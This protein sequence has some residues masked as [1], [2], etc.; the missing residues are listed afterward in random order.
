MSDGL[1]PGGMRYLAV[2]HVTADVLDDRGIQPG[3]TALYSALQAARLGLSATI[4]TRGEPARVRALLAPFED[5]I[6]LIVQP[7]PE[8]TT[9][10]TE[11]SGA[12]RRQRVLSW[13]GPI[14]TGALPAAEILHLAPV[15]AELP[16]PAPGRWRFVGL[17]PQGYARR[18][19][20][21]GATLAS[22]AADPSF[23]LSAGRCDAVVISVLERDS[24]AELLAAA[25]AAGAVAAVTAGPSPMEIL[26]PGGGS[27][28]V[29]V[30]SLAEPVDDLGAGDVYAAAFFAA[31]AR[32]DE[33]AAAARMARAAAALRMIGR[34]PGAVANAEAIGE[35][36]AREG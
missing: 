9:F 10:A 24:C 19:D 4:V 13:A 35:R 28:T 21:A 30:S 33:P 3:G 29:A 6:E 2:G 27:E 1:H 12:A 36:A 34:G 17:T 15:A 31:L 7:A 32:G 26:L 8:T 14:D 22:C 16:E 23:A 25:L 20:G 5:E 11:G 18:W